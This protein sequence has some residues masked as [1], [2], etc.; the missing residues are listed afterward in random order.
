MKK[1]HNTFLNNQWVK[2]EIAR[3]TIKYLEASENKNTA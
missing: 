3:E 1:L 2:G